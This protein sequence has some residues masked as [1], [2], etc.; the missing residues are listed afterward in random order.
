[1]FNKS[2]SIKPTLIT[3]IYRGNGGETSRA[4]KWGSPALNA[5]GTRQQRRSPS[6]TTSAAQCRCRMLYHCQHE[7]LAQQRSPR[8]AAAV[9]PRDEVG[10]VLSF[11]I[12]YS[13]ILR[14]GC[15]VLRLSLGDGSGRFLN[16]QGVHGECFPCPP[17][18]MLGSFWCRWSRHSLSTPD[19][20]KVGQQP[21]ALRPG[22][23]H[24][25]SSGGGG[26]IEILASDGGNGF[27]EVKLS[28]E[29]VQVLHDR[30]R[31]LDWVHRKGA[32]STLGEE[33]CPC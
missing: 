22:W 8:A 30:F 11:T 17:F 23:D 6:P 15:G 29:H 20:A 10:L 25:A 4:S 33:V 7:T 26:S 5:V 9:E 32:K 18:C 16:G 27:K 13:L 12:G 24:A 21:F 31:H 28:P 14:S 3:W 19:A 1:M 2:T